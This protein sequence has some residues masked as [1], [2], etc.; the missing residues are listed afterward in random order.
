MFS[1]QYQVIH[2]QIVPCSITFYVKFHAHAVDAHLKI[3]IG[4]CNEFIQPVRRNLACFQW[5]RVPSYRTLAAQQL[6][7]RFD[8]VQRRKIIYVSPHNC[9]ALLQSIRRRSKPT[10]SL[11]DKSYR[12]I[13]IRLSVSIIFFLCSGQHFSGCSKCRLSM[14]FIHMPF[15]Y[16]VFDIG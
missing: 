3:R 14:P 12:I 7:Q 16:K 4:R 15:N 13:C 11:I 9:R 5:L 6:Q 2:C 1:C 8:I 10:D